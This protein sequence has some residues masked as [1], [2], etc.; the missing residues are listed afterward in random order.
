MFSLRFLIIP[1]GAICTIAAL[2]QTTYATGPRQPA[3]AMMSEQLVTC[4][5]ENR[6]TVD[7][8]IIADSVSH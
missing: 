3:A 8:C 1:L 6:T 4:T 7:I 2:S 5:D